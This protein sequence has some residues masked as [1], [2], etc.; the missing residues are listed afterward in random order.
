MAANGLDKLGI[1]TADTDHYLSVIKQRVEKR[2]TGSDWQR[3]FIE[4]NGNDFQK[5]TQQY[6]YHQQQGKVVSEWPV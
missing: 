6:L 4:K 2:Q 5:L 1:A 3:A